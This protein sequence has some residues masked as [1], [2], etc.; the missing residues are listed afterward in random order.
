MGF[1]IL[2]EKSEENYLGGLS[3]RNKLSS[4][5]LTKSKPRCMTLYINNP[6]HPPRPGPSWIMSCPQQHHHPPVEVCFNLIFDI[7]NAII[8]T[9][10]R[11]NVRLSHHRDLPRWCV[12]LVQI[13]RLAEVLWDAHWDL[14]NT[15]VQLD[16]GVQAYKSDT[17]YLQHAGFC[18]ADTEFA[19]K[20]GPSSTPCAPGPTIVLDEPALEWLGTP[21]V[22]PHV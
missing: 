6:H 7:F 20:P 16:V 11:A 10:F 14:L 19:A 9:I 8:D 5:S 17:C 3:W 18:T 1:L 15:N 4:P 2:F 13:H 12:F 22:L 21:Q